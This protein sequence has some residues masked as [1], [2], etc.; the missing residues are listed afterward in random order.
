MVGKVESTRNLQEREERRGEDTLHPSLKALPI[1][2]QS[3]QN[4]IVSQIPICLLL[5]LVP[6]AMRGGR[7][8]SEVQ[9]KIRINGLNGETSA[10]R[11]SGR[12]MIRDR[13]GNQEGLKSLTLHL[14][15]AIV[16][17]SILVGA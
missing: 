15:I 1:L 9:R 13:N 8:E 11:K 3:P 5:T 17:V 10:M 14:F 6:R 12:C 7:R 4:L 16:S 2:R